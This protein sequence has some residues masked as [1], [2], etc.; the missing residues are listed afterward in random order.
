ME[1]KNKL[2]RHKPIEQNI[3]LYVPQVLNKEPQIWEEL[4]VIMIPET[5]FHFSSIMCNLQDTL[6]TDLS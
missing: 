6:K 5:W 1:R 2:L 4:L 3:F